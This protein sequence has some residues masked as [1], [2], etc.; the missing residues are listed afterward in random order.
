MQSTTVD[1][2][3]MLSE[4]RVG[5]LVECFYILDEWLRKAN[6]LASSYDRRMTYRVKGVTKV[7]DYY[8]EERGSRLCS[9][10][11]NVE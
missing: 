9:P 1:I 6:P 3:L 2:C 8:I 5:P 10:Y 4:N 7:Y 11:K